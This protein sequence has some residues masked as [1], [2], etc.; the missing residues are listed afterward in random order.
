MKGEL[1]VF[2]HGQLV[3]CGSLR[4]ISSSKEKAVVFL[5][6]GMLRGK[7]V[8]QDVMASRTRMKPSE[9]SSA[10]MSLA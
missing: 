2:S 5:Q 10:D 9:G 6:L 3:R 4:V 7:N 8:H 1:T